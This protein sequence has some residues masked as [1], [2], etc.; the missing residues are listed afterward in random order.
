MRVSPDL[1]SAAGGVLIVD[2]DSG[3]IQ[4]VAHMLSGMG[5]LRFAM[6]GEDALRLVR[7]SLPDVVLLD[8]EMPGMSGFDVCRA[9]KADPD[10][11]DAPVIFVTSHSEVAWELEGFAIGA[12]D[13]ITK[14]VSEPLLRARVG[15]QLRMKRLTDELRR[16]STVDQL[17]GVANRRRFDETLNNEWRRATREGPL[18]LLMVD[19]DHFKAFNDTYGHPEGDV[20]LRDV[21]TALERTCLRP[22]DLVARY[23][24][25]EFSIILPHT[26]AA[27]AA[28]VAQRVLAAITALGVPHARSPVAPHLTV[29]VGVGTTAGSES[30]SRGFDAVP[31]KKDTV[32]PPAAVDLVRAADRALYA[33]KRAGRA[34]AAVAGIAEESPVRILAP[35]CV[36]DE[37]NGRAADGVSEGWSPLPDR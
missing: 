4:L 18:S 32:V 23:G 17:T 36:P 6:R 26:T 12:A 15:T 8:A 16:L 7:E 20:C 24:G 34:R 30:L 28:H 11:A 2:D 9:L 31:S 37:S 29:S 25:E 10:T 1:P 35:V 13:F 5:P 3:A 27:G 33:A 14:P 21:A 19:V 22:S